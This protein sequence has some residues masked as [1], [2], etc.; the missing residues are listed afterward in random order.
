VLMAR[1]LCLILLE[2]CLGMVFLVEIL[3]RLM[4]TSIP[5]RV[6]PIV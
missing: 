1:L 6:I 5:L 4:L 3:M 2:L